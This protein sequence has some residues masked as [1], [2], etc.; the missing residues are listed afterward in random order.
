MR[1]I[2][3]MWAYAPFNKKI[4]VIFL[5]ITIITSVGVGIVSYQLSKK[6]ITNSSIEK[7]QN[8]A[9]TV[10]DSVD[11]FFTAADQ[12]FISIY[13]NPDLMYILDEKGP[14]DE[15]EQNKYRKILQTAVEQGQRLNNS[16]AYINV[17]GKNGFSFTD[18][19][20]YSEENTD[21]DSCVGYYGGYGLDT[22]K[23]SALWVPNQSSN[24]G[25]SITRLITLVRYTRDIYTLETTG[26][27]TLGITESSLCR[28]YT[29]PNSDI[30]I[31]GIDG[32]V[33]S[34]Y[35]KSLIG[36]K[37]EL[38]SINDSLKSGPDVG[39]VEFTENDGTRLFATYARIPE[40][41][42]Y[43]VS[44]EDYYEI[45]RNNYNLLGNI[46]LIL[47]IAVIVSTA[48]LLWA[49]KVL[50]ASLNSLFSTM[51][52]VMSG[53]LSVRFVP[54]GS[55]EVNRAGLYLNKMLDQINEDIH[56]REES[57]RMARISDLRLLQSQIN[58]HLLYNTLDSVHFHLE[59]A[60]YKKASDILKSMSKFFKLSLSQGDILIPMER[61]MAL[62]RV[63]LDIQRICREKNI[64]LKITGDIPS[65]L[66]I[67]KMTVQ[68]IIENSIMHG[69]QGNDGNNQI[70][71]DIREYDNTMT[72]TVSDN[73]IG[74][75]DEV[76][77]R[78]NENIASPRRGLEQKHFGLWNVDQRLKNTFGD[79]SGIFLESEFGEY[80]RTIITIN[81][82]SVKNG[83]PNV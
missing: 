26:V 51:E 43:L 18:Y 63:Y 54:S 66:M 11:A 44:L 72:I 42:W 34:H 38:S 6:V 52:K 8:A 65:H 48:V 57:E 35:D 30:F 80:T 46:C 55:D 75:T 77:S 62:I 23:T 56:Y 1:K 28:K 22:G 49:S 60:S 12:T 5:F 61:E 40:T 32:T 17:Y 71:I 24:I 19:Y 81:T 78:L 10:A 39:T 33:I 27:M 29:S 3:D 59:T 50:T 14:I 83:V 67:P 13:S 2:K 69:F 31:V 16:V 73:G 53:D 20:Y 82:N 45:F 15:S 47:L 37:L 79:E 25:F 36:S 76:C 74:M 4:A 64:E 9:Q 7:S 21:F 68:P 58:P 70:T 41:G